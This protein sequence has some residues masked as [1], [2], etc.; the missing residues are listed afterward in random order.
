MSYPETINGTVQFLNTGG[1]FGFV[2]SEYGNHLFNGV[3]DLQIGDSVTFSVSPV[4][5]KGP[6]AINVVKTA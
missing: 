2:T 1:D 6:Q 4:G 5:P 3:G